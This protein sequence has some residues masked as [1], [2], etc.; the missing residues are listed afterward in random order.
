MVTLAELTEEVAGLREEVSSLRDLFTRR[1]YDD[2]QKA[3]LISALEEGAHFSF[4]EPFL[5]DVFLL[6][7]RLERADGCDD[8]LLESVIDELMDMVSRRGVER[9]RVTPTFDAARMRAVKVTSCEGLEV[10]RVMRV[11]RDGYTLSGKVVR[12]AEVIVARPTPDSCPGVQDAG[13]PPR[14]A[15]ENAES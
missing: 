12:P 10:P 1:L 2:R 8:D 11:V 9:I 5:S 13:A 7:D 14:H 15:Q 4:V 3:R 6:V